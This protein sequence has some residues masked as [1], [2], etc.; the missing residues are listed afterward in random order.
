LPDPDEGRPYHHGQLRDALLAAAIALEPAHGPLGL[1]LRQ[2]AKHAGV[3][4]AAVYNHFASK[5]ALVVA[6]A[7]LGFAQLTAALSETL[8]RPGGGRAHPPGYAGF[9]TLGE[10]AR[11][12]VRFA[13]RHASLFRFMFGTPPQ[14]G[15][16]LADRQDAVLALFARA[17]EMAQADGT[18]RR[19]VAARYGAQLWSL[20]H[21]V[22]AL[23]AND[24][25]DGVPRG[26]QGKQSPSVRERRALDVTQ[27]AVAAFVMGVK[28]PLHRLAGLGGDGSQ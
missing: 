2:V 22:A 3:S 9:F 5:D 12:Y 7:D 21:G 25:L 27:G 16:S 1:S 4:H 15:A 28:D 20:V 24:A 23:S 10:I 6:V 13:S 14:A 11:A 8:A 17:I 19:G 26:R 18:V